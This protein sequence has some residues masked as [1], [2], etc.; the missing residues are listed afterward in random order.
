MKALLGCEHCGNLVR[1]L[2]AEDVESCARCGNPMRDMGLPEAR[3]LSREARV[4]EQ[5]R[6]TAGLHGATFPAAVSR[7]G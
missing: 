7:T 5:F 6:R 3:A 2:H 1:R 4:A